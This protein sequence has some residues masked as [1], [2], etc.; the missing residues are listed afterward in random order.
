MKKIF[1]LSVLCAFALAG[2]AEQEKISSES[3]TEPVTTAEEA[4]E[5]ETEA[6][7]ETE[8]EPETQPTEPYVH[9]DDGYFNL[10]E[11][12][13]QFTMG[14]QVQGTCWA[15]AGAA[16]M[17][18]AYSMK[19]GSS[20]EI[21][22]LE[23]VDIIYNKE[24]PEGFFLADG[25]NKRDIGG[26]ALFIGETLSNGFGGLTVDRTVALK[27]VDS[28]DQNECIVDIGT[29]KIKDYVRSNG[30]VVISVLDFDEKKGWNHGYFTMNDPVHDEPD[31]DVALIG[32]DDHFPKEY[33]NV[34]A[35]N[36]GAW[37][38]YNSS[39]GSAG[40]YYI[41]YDTGFYEAFGLSV[42]DEYSDVLSYDCGTGY[43]SFISLG[44]ET[45]MANVFNKPGTLAAVGTFC[46]MPDEEITIEVY[47]E[48][49]SELLYSQDAVLDYSGYHTIKLDKP[50]EVDKYALAI[51]YKGTAPVEPDYFSC[52]DN[53]NIT[54]RAVNEKGQSY[55]LI[56]EQWKDLADEDIKEVLGTDFTPKNA[57]IKALY[58]N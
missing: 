20:V 44:D 36:D 22:P 33:F 35:K 25:V 50:M 18:S 1:I 28:D 9:G 4:T 52:D 51:R 34:P 39:L 56:G 17:E 15:F 10:A 49:F 16:A 24:H 37:I 40:Y 42:T 29:E 45:V 7:T 47:T 32:W 21:D 43:N 53:D 27:A 6:V 57:C 31:H 8:T 13:N 54:F 46:H 38:C 14:S 58:T 11:E 26:Y 55:V 19:N 41:S 3:I 30:A 23:I 5:S 48:D 12:G 2:C